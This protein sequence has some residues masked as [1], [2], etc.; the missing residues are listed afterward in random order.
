MKFPQILYSWKSILF[1]ALLLRLSGLGL[2]PVGLSHD[3]ELHNLINAKSLAITGENVPGVVAGILTQNGHCLTGDCVYGELETY[4]FIPWMKFLP[5]DIVLSKIPFVLASVGLVWAIGK[6]FENLSKNKTI[7]LISGLLVAINPWAIYYGRTAY[8]YTFAF[9]F[10][11]LAAYFFTRPKS[12]KSNLILGGLSALI[13]SGF[14][15]GAKPI[16]P[17]VI[18]WGV[19]F[20]LYQFK[21][22][23]LK[24]TLLYL[25]IITIV[26]GGYFLILFNSPGGKRFLE[27]GLSAGPPIL[28][29]INAYLGFFSPPSLFMTGQRPT[30][31]YFVSGH[32]Y[33][34][35]LELPFL[36]LGIITIARQK[37]ARLLFALIAITIAPAA[38]KT[39]G[40]SIYSLRSGLTYPLISGI[41][42]WGLYFTAKK[43]SHLK[44]FLVFIGSLY[45]VSLTYFLFLYWHKLP[46]EQAT[47]WFFHER[48][49]TN[50]IT[51]VKK[52][53]DQK[54]IILTARPDGIFNSYV[55]FGGFYNNYQ[56]IQEVNRSYLDGTF[57][58]RGVRFSSD[59]HLLTKQDLSASVIFIDQVN[60]INCGLDQRNSPKIANPKD[61]GGMFNI[62]NE[63]L[64]LAYPKKRFP[65]PKNIYDFNLNTLNDEK[66][67]DLWITNP[68]NYN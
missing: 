68:D 30:D 6:L 48:V 59:C 52:V 49:L 33:Y 60:Q 8:S 29:R 20:N 10:Y 1:L 25:L 2:N 67:C 28:D 55:F 4:A 31:N 47:R 18:L 16:L 45:I 41:I 34:Y 58:Y 50:Y 22:R 27:I 21:F 64:C 57:E 44:V 13:A 40:A 26:I 37:L 51:R 35:L 5:L 9:F 54:I 46:K 36:I 66:F 39:S 17:L 7:G 3:D 65:L 14:Y 19:I 43:T 32:G 61:A 53:S 15:F 38:L 42:A 12:Y 23:H 24:F 56:A 63:S 62:L 11:I